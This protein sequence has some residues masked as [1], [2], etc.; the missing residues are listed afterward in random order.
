VLST[1]SKPGKCPPSQGH[2]SVQDSCSA[3][4]DGGCACPR[5]LDREMSPFS[6][7]EDSP[8][9]SSPR[10]DE[11]AFRGTGVL[12]GPSRIAPLAPWRGA[13]PR[14]LAAFGCNRLA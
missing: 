11:S 1:L 9:N 8:P 14:A 12:S 3:P 5:A 10:E 7:V 2:R 4:L 13:A 6:D